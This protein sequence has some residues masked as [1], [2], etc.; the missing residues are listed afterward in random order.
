MKKDYVETNELDELQTKTYVLN[1]EE[2]KK[3]E[4]DDEEEAMVFTTEDED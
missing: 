2:W 1:L 4:D 3:E